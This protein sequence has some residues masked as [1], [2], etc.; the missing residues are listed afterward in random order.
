[1]IRKLACRALLAIE[2]RGSHLLKGKVQVNKIPLAVLA[3]IKDRPSTLDSL[4]RVKVEPGGWWCYPMHLG[5]H[6]V[7][8]EDQENFDDLQTDERFNLAEQ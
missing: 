7:S 2:T 6:S 5:S 1:M 8:D 3:T 4:H